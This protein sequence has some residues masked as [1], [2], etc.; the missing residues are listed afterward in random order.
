[1]KIRHDAYILLKK[2]GYNIIFYI[3]NDNTLILSNKPY[4]SQI[5]VNNKSNVIYTFFGSQA[6][7]KIIEIY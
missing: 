5:T 7:F 3:G 6:V 4:D 2:L 1:M